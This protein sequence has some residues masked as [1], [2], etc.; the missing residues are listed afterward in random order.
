TVDAGT[1]DNNQLI[2]D[3]SQTASANTNV[4]VTSTTITGLSPIPI[5]YQATSGNYNAAANAGGIVLRDSNTF[6]ATFAI[7]STLGGSSTRIDGN[8]GT[9]KFNVASDLATN[10]GNLN[11]IAGHLIL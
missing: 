11:T 6:G 10:Q 2:L 7:Q 3:D 9:E 8:G 5:V 1:G 4:T